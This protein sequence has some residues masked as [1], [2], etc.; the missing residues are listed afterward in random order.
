MTHRA[1]VK[2]AGAVAPLLVYQIVARE[3]V[4]EEG[5]R[6]ARERAELRLAGVACQALQVEEEPAGGQHRIQIGPYK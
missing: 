2:R 4:A 1:R 5:L 6:R 3:L